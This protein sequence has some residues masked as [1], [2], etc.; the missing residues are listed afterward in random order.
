[1]EGPW[2]LFC[3]GASPHFNWKYSR[4]WPGFRRMRVQHGEE[5]TLVDIVHDT[6]AQ[7]VPL[8]SK[9]FIM[10]HRVDAIEEITA[11]KL[12]AILG[13]SDVKDLVDLFFISR[14]GIDVLVFLPEASR[15]DAGMDPSTL[16]W[17]LSG[18][19]L[20]LS[21]LDL[22]RPLSVQELGAFRDTLVERLLKL[23]WPGNDPGNVT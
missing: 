3:I 1:M 17:V 16:A 7:L 21:S 2:I 4:T 19:G 8:N 5:S 10:H 6:V 23:A 20:D 18:I 15:K 11:N 13:R 14:L 22:V 12:C 9:P